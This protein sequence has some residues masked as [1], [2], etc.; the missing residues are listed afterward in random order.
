MER[1]RPRQAGVVRSVKP[2]VLVGRVFCKVLAEQQ[3]GVQARVED[4]LI[5][6]SFAFPAIDFLW[7]DDPIAIVVIVPFWLLVVEEVVG[8]DVESPAHA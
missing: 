5:R 3:A 4:S 1:S 6:E 7:M 2:V 8:G